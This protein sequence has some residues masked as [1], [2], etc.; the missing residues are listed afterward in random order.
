MIV[1]ITV[2]MFCPCNITLRVLYH[3][4]IQKRQLLS[5]VDGGSEGV[6]MIKEFIQR[7]SVMWPYCDGV[8][9]VSEPK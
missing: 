7:Y 8:I 5:E 6:E 2:S 1:K 4:N 3:F 9:H